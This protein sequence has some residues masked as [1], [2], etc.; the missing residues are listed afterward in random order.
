M[1]YKKY[2]EIE[3]TAIENGWNRRHAASKAENAFFDDAIRE[4]DIER[5][6]KGR[7]LMEIAWD[8]GH[9]SGYPEVFNYAQD[10]VELIKD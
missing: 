10:L 7:R 2:T 9:S 8:L 5:H 4:L 6:P 1:D 3:R